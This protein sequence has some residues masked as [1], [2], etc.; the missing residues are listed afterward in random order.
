MDFANKLFFIVL[1]DSHY[2]R[3]RKLSSV[4][5]LFEHDR[6]V[7]PRGMPRKEPLSREQI[8]HTDVGV[9]VLLPG[10]VTSNRS[11]PSI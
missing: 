11:G 5:Y 7:R 9:K 1:L 2:N 10:I 4:P 3:R 6:H 8:A